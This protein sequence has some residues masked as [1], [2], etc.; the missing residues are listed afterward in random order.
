[1]MSHQVHAWQVH[2]FW[3]HSSTIIRWGLKLKLPHIYYTNVV[4]IVAT[5][6][7]P[8]A[9]CHPRTEAACG[10]VCISLKEAFRCHSIF[11][12]TIAERW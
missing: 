9:T 4:A 2:H 3:G 8:L 5:C 6:L 12:G 1:M 10:I 11:L 7:L